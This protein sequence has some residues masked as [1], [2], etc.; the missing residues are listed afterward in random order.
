MSEQQ[1]T[2]VVQE[3][4]APKGYQ[5]WLEYWDTQGMP[6]RN[7]P[8]L[9]EERQRF[10]TERRAIV[11]DI[12]QG[13]YP[14]KDVKL[15]RAEVEWLLATHEHEGEK[16]PVYSHDMDALFLRG[17]DLRGA[18]LRAAD[19]SDLPLTSLLGSLTP[20]ELA[21]LPG[22]LR[23]EAIAKAA[24]RL[25]GATL[26][27]AHLEAAILTGAHLERAHLEKAHLEAA[28]L[29]EALLSGAFIIHAHMEGSYLID[30]RLND[31]TAFGVHLEGAQ[32]AG[33]QV[34][35]TRL[36][37]AHLE[38]ALL[39]QARLEATVLKEAHLEGADLRQAHLEGAMLNGATL[40]GKQMEASDLERIRRWQPTF[41]A[42]QSGSDLRK[43]TFDAR[44]DLKAVCLCDKVHGSVHIA[45]AL[46][47]GVNLAVVDW[48]H[49]TTLGED[50]EAEKLDKERPRRKQEGVAHDIRQAA[51]RANRQLAGALRD[52]NLNEEAD[53]FSYSAQLLHTRAIRHQSGK[54]AEWLFREVLDKL[55][56]FGYHW[57]RTVYCYAGIVAFSTIVYFWQNL[58][59]LPHSPWYQSLGQAFVAAITAL[60]GRGFFPESAQS[61]VQMAMA[62]LDAVAGLVIEAS[63]VAT[64]TQRFFAR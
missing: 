56:G 28:M 26:T 49:V 53:R 9:D 27:D 18:D 41:L 10:L 25:N 63:F 22:A 21:S 6:W 30:A 33:A 44:T 50:Q 13:I 46:Y 57:E 19:L 48:K 4:P 39:V 23:Q 17:L 38:G 61:G 45:D 3:R 42:S 51:V 1:T 40:C 64:F 54:H 36:D 2:T 58:V 5:S 31:V 35:G 62:A 32:L 8:E 11:P 12:A 60:H 29:N 16:G 52:Q 14:F 7:E 59:F 20:N 34:Q 15:D 47:N 24:I 55:A 43:V 37:Y